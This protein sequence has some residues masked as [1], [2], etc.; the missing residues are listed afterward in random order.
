MSNTIQ[1]K[2]KTSAGAPSP[3]SLQTGEMCYVLPNKT[4]YVKNDDNT[5]TLVNSSGGAGLTTITG[6]AVLNFGSEEDAAVNT[7]A[8]ASITNANIKTVAF[9]PVETTETSLDDFKLNGLSFNIENIINNT[10][11]DIRGTA[12]NNATGNYTINYLINI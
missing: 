5:V 3:A 6:T 12:T 8:N 1:V 11:F 7:T 2:R 9:I 4:L 10:S